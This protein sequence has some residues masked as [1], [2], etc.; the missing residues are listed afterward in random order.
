MI[1]GF[2]PHPYLGGGN[3]CSVRLGEQIEPPAP[4]LSCGGAVRAREYTMDD[5]HPLVDCRCTLDMRYIRVLDVTLHCAALDYEAYRRESGQSVQS[6]ASSMCDLGLTGN[7]SLQRRNG[8]WQTTPV[9][10]KTIDTCRALAGADTWFTNK[11]ATPKPEA[12][13]LYDEHDKPVVVVPAPTVKATIS[14]LDPASI[15]EA[16][17]RAVGVPR[18]FLK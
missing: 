18:L 10:D 3:V 1:T 14:A 2:R 13:T 7:H 16:I 8:T 12:V 15:R 4:V 9:A 5:R 17:M 11:P 6:L